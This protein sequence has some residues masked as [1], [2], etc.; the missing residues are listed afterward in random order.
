[1]PNTDLNNLDR[2][3]R[4]VEKMVRKNAP[5][6]DID[7]YISSE[8]VSV[9]QIRAHKMAPI[10]YS[11]PSSAEVGARLTD[12]SGPTFGQEL[13]SA[14]KAA[15]PYLPAT[16]ATAGSIA[17]APETSGMSLIPLL[18][19]TLPTVTA[20]AGGGQAANYLLNPE[21][22]PETSLGRAGGIAKA[23]VAQGAAPEAIGGAAYIGGSKLLKPVA[24]A[25]GGGI[26]KVKS[27][28]EL[29]R[30]AANAIDVMQDYM[31]PR[32]PKTISE[33]LIGRDP[34][35]VALTP[36]Q[37]TTNQFVDL[38]ENISSG[39]L[40]GGKL[41]RFK[42]QQ[43]DLGEEAAQS[44]VQSLR[45]TD[46]DAEQLG[47]F[48]TETILGEKKA[49]HATM[50]GRYKEVDNATKDAIVNVESPYNWLKGISEGR[51]SPEIGSSATGKKIIDAIVND[52]AFA[53][54]KIGFM[55]ADDL[56]SRIMKEVE[57]A[58][59]GNSKDPVVG[60]GT[61]LVQMLGT[62]MDVAAKGLPPAAKDYY[63]ATRQL[64]KE[65]VTPFNKKLVRQ[66]MKM[67][68]AVAED[69]VEKV[70]K[71]TTSRRELSY[72]KGLV[73]A[74]TFSDM[75]GI[76]MER[77]VA[78]ATTGGVLQGKALATTIKRMKLNGNFDEIFTPEQAK[79]IEGI[80]D[81]LT[82][83]QAKPGGTGQM[84][85]Q[86]AQAGAAGG[87]ATG[88]YF[89]GNEKKGIA[90]GLLILGGPAIFARM[91]TK[92]QTARLLIHGMK[93]PKGSPQLASLVIRLNQEIGRI[94]KEL[95]QP[96]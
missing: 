58:K 65:G 49:F 61:K 25:I 84:W 85:I 26:R 66:I 48:A 80:V 50:R 29:E 86:F 39:G 10:Q 60:L 90:G 15:G 9:E 4:N 70:F 16:A 69:V 17:L 31:G 52:E 19:R 76:W 62:Q 72:V 82:L 63:E 35:Q 11:D 1:M 94:E 41:Y 59:A 43:Q 20:L 18:L 3:K 47:D 71:P 83:S 95:E 30:G 64:Y 55:Q 74:D 32:K 56:R 36:G 22:A 34:Y 21:S 87:I 54:G 37:A 78:K 14:A 5:K 79:R 91:L 44:F 7:R 6:A 81:F 68:E 67:D 73:G 57:A 77:E 93:L 45:K 88:A 23:A 13:K 75:T 8:G 40:F 27:A 53:S 96:K 38:M 51:I 28:P 24:Q 12:T 92:P 46:Y 2:V 89:T 42:R 33:A